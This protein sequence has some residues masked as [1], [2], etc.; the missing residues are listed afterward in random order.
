M[1]VKK[2][3]LYDRILTVAEKLFIRYGYAKTSLKLI[4]EKCYISK[5]NIYRYFSSKEEIYETLVGEARRSILEV[6]DRMTAP[7]FITKSLK[8]FFFI[9]DFIR[10]IAEKTRQFCHCEIGTR[11][12]INLS[13]DDRIERRIGN[14]ALDSAGSDRGFSFL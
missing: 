12:D 11:P 9:Y 1:Q 2:E 8:I 4:A 6:T 10:T 14:L 5:S 7:D 13:F 3:E